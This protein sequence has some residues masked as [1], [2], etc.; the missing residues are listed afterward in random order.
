MIP[1]PPIHAKVLNTLI[2]RM[3]LT[4]KIR[5]VA[6]LNDH[7]GSHTDRRDF[8]VQ[9]AVS[10]V[11]NRLSLSQAKVSSLIPGVIEKTALL[12]SRVGSVVLNI[13][14]NN[15]FTNFDDAFQMDLP[16]P[17]VSLRD[18]KINTV[19]TA[20]NIMTEGLRT[21]RNSSLIHIATTHKER[22]FSSSML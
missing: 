14:N 4:C 1:S 5:S 19:E 21:S 12:H 20:R 15:H 18:E 10:H 16:H 11:R 13:H 8:I 3:T 22:S 2:N 6:E 17:T 7:P 9:T